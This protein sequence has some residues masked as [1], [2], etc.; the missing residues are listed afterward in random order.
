VPIHIIRLGRLD[1]PVTPLK[2]RG[3]FPLRISAA[4]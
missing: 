2:V 4:S 1:G 3:T